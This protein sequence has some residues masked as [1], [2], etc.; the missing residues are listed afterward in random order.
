MKQSVAKYFVTAL[1]MAALLSVGALPVAASECT[2][3]YGSTVPC[4]PINLTINKQV[5]DPENGEYVENVTTAKFSQG[6]K[7]NFKLIV[8]NSSG[9][10]FHNV[11][12][13]D[14]VPD[15]VVIDQADTDYLNK[16][17]GKV[18]TISDDKK[19]VEFTIDEFP[20]GRTANM[21]VM[22]HL[23]GPYPTDNE[24]CRDNWAYVTATER[25]DGDKNF[26]RFCVA[27]KVAGA[28]K[29]PVAGVEDIVYVLPFITTGLAGAALTL[30]KRS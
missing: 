22:A 9:E 26:A 20:A 27:N 6:N 29:L 3:Q 16:D 30:K 8:T 25:P 18:F 7:I 21:Y 1:S 14:S 13:K 23:T 2:D 15:N 19:T 24:F 28:Q 11:K 12:V 17:G 4:G 5:Q 10:T